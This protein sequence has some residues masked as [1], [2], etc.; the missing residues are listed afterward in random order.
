MMHVY[1]RSGPVRVFNMCRTRTRVAVSDTSSRVQ[2]DKEE[3]L[4]LFTQFGS[5]IRPYSAY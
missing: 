3:S 5:D 2:P 1:L 4:G